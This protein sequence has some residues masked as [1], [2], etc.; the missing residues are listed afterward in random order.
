MDDR[1]II[2]IFYLTLG[3]ITLLAAGKQWLPREGM[4]THLDVLGAGKARAQTPAGGSF[5]PAPPTPSAPGIETAT[6]FQ[7]L[8]PTNGASFSGVPAAPSAFVPNPAL[9]SVVVPQP[10]DVP[11]AQELETTRVAARVGGEVILVGD[12]IS[13]VNAYLSRNGV[14]P[15]D[16]EVQAQKREFMKIRLKQIVE[17]RMIVNE[18]R[19]KIPEEGYKKAMEKFDEE[20]YKTVAPKM[21]AERKLPGVPEL[22]AQLRKDGTTLE[23]EQ[24]AFAEQV[25]S[26]SWVSQNTKINK[27]IAHAELVEYYQRNGAKYEFPAQARWEQITVRFDSFPSKAEAYAALAAAGNQVLQGKLFSD[28]A[29][30]MSQ[31]STASQGGQH[32]WTKKGSLVSKVL[33]EALF[34]LPLKQ[35]SPIIEDDRG[36]HIIRV[37]ERIDAGK[38]PFADVQLEIR[39]LILEQR[40]EVAKKTLLED[41]RKRTAVWTMF[42]APSDSVASPPDAALRR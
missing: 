9:P 5:I 16:P 6:S 1:S 31:G 27:D 22:E 21:A 15:D 38:K 32:P 14:S 30:E 41:I 4:P 36:F 7:P 37:I 29:R 33:D 2:K 23:R 35:L 19:R 25:L 18:A 13:S 28:V 42:D 20:F 40:T 26:N 12:V 24:R 39:N 17:T 34:T 11:P 3:S 8:P 10:A